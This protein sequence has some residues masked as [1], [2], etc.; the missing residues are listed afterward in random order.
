[1]KRLLSDLCQLAAVI[2]VAG[3]AYAGALCLVASWH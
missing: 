2:I 1:M 3:L